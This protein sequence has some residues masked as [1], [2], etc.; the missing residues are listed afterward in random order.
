MSTWNEK[1]E[2]FSSRVIVETI[3]QW[4]VML[5][6]IAMM[7]G[8]IISIV[9]LVKNYNKIFNLDPA[10]LFLLI[11]KLLLY[12]VFEFAWPSEFLKFLYDILHMSILTIMFYM[13]SQRL[14][15]SRMK[16]LS[17]TRCYT[18]SF[19]V[20]QI[21]LLV[22]GLIFFETSFECQNVNDNH[23]HIVIYLSKASI[24]ALVVLNLIMTVVIIRQS[25]SSE[26]TRSEDERSVMFDYFGEEKD[27]KVKRYQLKFLSWG[28]LIY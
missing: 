8:L 22:C 2:L 24:F 5:L 12:A 25:K 13:F 20:F 11:V 26:I 23:T 16:C 14:L 1:V 19:V 15:Q 4:I 28:L 17:H 3:R 7:T 9:I 27:G 18:S 21:V 6:I 10:I